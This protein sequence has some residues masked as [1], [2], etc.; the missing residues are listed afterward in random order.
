MKIIRRATLEQDIQDPRDGLKRIREKILIVTDKRVPWTT[1]RTNPAIPQ[2][3]QE[4]PTERGMFVEDRNP[5]RG[6]AT[7]WYIEVEYTSLENSKVDIN[8]L[9]RPA[10]ITWSTSELQ[11]PTLT[12]RLGRPITTT[13]GEFIPGLTKTITIVEYRVR[14]NVATDPDWLDT[15]LHT[16]N[17]DAIQIRGK[18]RRPLTL[19]LAAASGGEYQV[20]NRQRYFELDYTLIYNPIGWVEDIWNLGTMELVDQEVRV[21]VS[22]RVFETRIVKGLSPIKVGTPAKPVDEPVPLDINGKAIVDHLTPGSEH[23]M[24]PRKLVTLRIEIDDHRTFSG[25][26]PLK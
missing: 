25:V 13:A 20:E 26:I 12:D 24:D 22:P 14:K 4:H 11:I 6:R 8:P 3:G 16:L 7:V 2:P 5:K 18:V 17:Q 15:H 21:E 1:V 23:P 10:V 9:S 19:V